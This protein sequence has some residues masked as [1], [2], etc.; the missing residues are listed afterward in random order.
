[1]AFLPRGSLVGEV[2]V[3]GPWSDPVGIWGLQR[4][5]VM[6]A[7]DGLGKKTIYGELQEQERARTY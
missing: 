3:G 1:M 2:A 7:G 6:V 5:T 4:V